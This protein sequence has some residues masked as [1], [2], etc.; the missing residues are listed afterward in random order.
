LIMWNPKAKRIPYGIQGFEMLRRDNCY[1]V[2]KTRFIQEIEYANKYFFL[3]RPRRF[4]KTLTM[5]MLEAYYDINKKDKFEEIFSGLW[6]G[7]NPTESR[8]S[9]L[10]LELNFAMVNGNIEDYKSSFNSY[11]DLRFKN[12]CDI[13]SEFFPAN[14]KE[15][16]E[17]MN[18]NA[19][20]ELK[21]IIQEIEKTDKKIYLFIDEYDNFTNNILSDYTQL[22]RYMDETH[23]T[24]YLRTFFN[25]IKDGSKTA[26]ERLFIT[27]VSPVTLDDLTSGFNIGTNYTTD[28]RFNEITGFTEQE[29]R[30]MLTYY[31]GYFKFPCS[32]DEIIETI[33]PWY[34]NY[35]FAEDCYGETTMYNSDMLLYFIDK[36]CN[37]GKLPK[38]I[39]DSNIRTDYAKLKMLIRKDKEMEFEGSIIQNLITD[40]QITGK[41]N[42]HFPAEQIVLQDNFISLLY[43]FGMIT[44]SGF[45][46]DEVIFKI[47]NVVVK[48]QLI[49]YL[50]D[51]YSDNELAY[52]TWS[53]GKLLSRMAFHGEWK[54]FFE[55][56][57]QSIKTFATTRD[58]AK[59]EKFLH[60][61]TLATTCQSKAYFPH[62]EAD[63]SAGFPDL[64]LEPRIDQYPDLKHSYLI[65][66]KYV[67]E[68]ATA[69]EIQNKTDEATA[70]LQK[71]SKYGLVV[72]KSKNTTLHCLLVMY[73]G[74]DLE[75]C[76]EV[77][78][79]PPNSN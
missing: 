41:L 37:N 5:T 46:E 77:L 12:F 62:S 17:K 64:Y 10:V 56:V 20:D 42:D 25:A 50:M 59:G 23:R 54:P 71:Y 69:T 68:D 65:E 1:Y 76:E 57:S 3:V 34:D 21:Y 24:G 29:A 53:G 67:K 32:V 8:N 36:L 47:P 31:S 14:A 63:T 74:F 19:V 52:D 22:G 2:D 9:Y 70:Q 40:G 7:E 27:G 61:F 35:C 38:N 11:C 44:I 6:I 39:I 15:E 75:K 28:P 30:E 73:K 45:K 58:K 26:I 43:Y 49:N 79:Y 55:Y 13:Y 72:Q 78:N 4:G 66:F 48:E 18:K 60:G 16:L 51:N 33:R